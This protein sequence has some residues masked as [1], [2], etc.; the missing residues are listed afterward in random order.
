MLEEENL[1]DI[2]T[3]QTQWERKLLD[4]SLR[5]M[6]INM[7]MT[8]AVVPLLSADMSTLEDALADGE[9]FYVLPRPMEMDVNSEDN[10][11]IEKLSDL[12]SY[13]DY[14]AAEGKKR[15][16]HALYEEKDLSAC[17]TKLYR[18]ARMSLEEKGASTLFLA[19]GL[20]RWF[21][22]KKSTAARYAPIVLVPI[23][24]NRKSAGK[25]YSMRMRDEDAQVNITL[26]EFLKQN[27][28]IPISGLNP[29]PEDEHGLDIPRIFDI[30]REA[31][32]HMP[33]WDVVEACFIGNFSFSQFVMWNDI[34]K[35]NDF[36]D[37]NKIVHGLMNGAVDWD[38]TIP[39]S[40]DSDEAYLPVAVDSSQLRAINMAAAGVSFVLHGPPGTGKS[41]TITAMIA[42]ALT[43]R[44]SVV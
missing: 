33:M 19:A 24:I 40:V 32:S 20:L 12:G 26:L 16:L 39:D 44:K 14:I 37:H 17:L 28:D 11:S 34:H 31:V 1:K 22:G 13:A 29:S 18:T 30:I 27:Y 4:L 7:R 38:C 9:E 21:E 15:R 35:K 36:L 5:N 23:D 6:L 43:D 2:V 41:Q 8:K 42:N 25:G 10:F 3:K